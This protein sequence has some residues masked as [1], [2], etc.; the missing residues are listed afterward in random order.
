MGAGVRL[1]PVAGIPGSPPV[2]DSVH[3]LLCGLERKKMG[4]AE[5]EY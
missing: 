2:G 5:H 4:E 1:G 3:W